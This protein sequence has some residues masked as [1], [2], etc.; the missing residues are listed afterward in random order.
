MHVPSF[1]PVTEE[2]VLL[3]IYEQYLLVVQVVLV[4]CDVTP[5]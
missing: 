2:V 4:L 1:G 5:H 3:I